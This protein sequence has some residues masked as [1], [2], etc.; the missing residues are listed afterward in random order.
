MYT[1]EDFILSDIIRNH[2]VGVNIT[3]VQF[4]T[5]LQL[6]TVEKNLTAHSLHTNFP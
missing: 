1:P 4:A 5:F 2:L 3:E 6:N